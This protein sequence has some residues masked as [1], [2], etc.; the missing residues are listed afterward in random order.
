MYEPKHVKVLRVYNSLAVSTNVL[1]HPLN[2]HICRLVS[3]YLGQREKG[4]PLKVDG[5]P[6]SGNLYAGAV[7]G[8]EETQAGSG[9]AGREA[10]LSRL[11]EQLKGRLQSL[12]EENQQ[13]EE[14]LHQSDARA[15]GATNTC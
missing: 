15:S 2:K 14:M 11:V 9:A 13:L 8:A 6:G 1:M 12:K 7:A 5:T 4:L 3:R 10:L